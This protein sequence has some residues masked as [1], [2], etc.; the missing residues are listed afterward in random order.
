MSYWFLH[1]VVTP[2]WLEVYVILMITKSE[3]IGLYTV[4]VIRPYRWKL[5]Q[6]Q[7]TSMLTYTYL[8][9]TTQKLS[10][11]FYLK[12]SKSEY[13]WSHGLPALKYELLQDTCSHEKKDGMPRGYTLGKHSSSSILQKIGY[14]RIRF[15]TASHI[16]ERLIQ[17]YRQNFD[18]TTP[19]F[20]DKNHKHLI[21]YKGSLI[22]GY[23]HVELS[24]TEPVLHFI[25][26]DAVYQRQSY[27][28]KLIS[29]IEAWLVYKTFLYSGHEPPTI[30]KFSRVLRF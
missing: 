6:D 12:P 4:I 5:F 14:N 8:K 15:V 20:T 3:D 26:I 2:F 23:A 22:I 9:K 13:P 19:D 27:A 30:S 7:K 11:I 16:S 17:T 1:I 25:V 21:M 24:S 29:F 28:R 10:S 18:R